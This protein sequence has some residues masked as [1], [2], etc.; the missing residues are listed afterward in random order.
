MRDA[1]SSAGGIIDHQLD[2][3]VMDDS[4]LRKLIARYLAAG[5]CKGWVA[6]G[7]GRSWVSRLKNMFRH[8]WQRPIAPA[9]DSKEVSE[10]ALLPFDRRSVEEIISRSY[11]IPR[12]LNII[13]FNILVEAATRRIA[14]IGMSELR[15]CW[16]ACRNQLRQGIR[17]DLRNLL[18]TMVQQQGGIQVD[19]VPD[20]LYAKLR[21]DTHE[22]LVPKIFRF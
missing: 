2:L 11:G 22:D 3:N 4:T 21:A 12:V 5:R 17:P 18:E 7:K 9:D 14:R 13:C 19:E 8:R 16:N 10:E 20:E 15:V 6:N 1:Y